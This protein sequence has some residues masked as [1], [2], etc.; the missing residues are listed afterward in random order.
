[1]S[2]AALNR[3]LT[4]HKGNYYHDV[5]FGYLN[6]LKA[7]WNQRKFWSN[8]SMAEPI[9]HSYFN[10]KVHIFILK[11]P[12]WKG[13]IALIESFDI[14]PWKFHVREKMNKNT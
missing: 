4:T 1:M 6:T 12:R 14:G 2:E 3:A 13:I 9:C 5:F 7:L 11:R 8:S 10:Y